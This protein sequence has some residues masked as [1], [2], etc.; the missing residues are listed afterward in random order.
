VL[1]DGPSIGAR[2][3]DRVTLVGK[4]YWGQGV[5]EAVLV[6]SEIRD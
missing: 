4:R 6:V 5:R 3:N 1:G 2:L